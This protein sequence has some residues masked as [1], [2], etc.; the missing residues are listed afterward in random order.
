M[1]QSPVS[2]KPQ[3]IRYIRSKINPDLVILNIPGS[4]E[5]VYI[6]RV[7]WSILN[8]GIMEY[9]NMLFTARYVF[10]YSPI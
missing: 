3:I 7:D 5:C 1:S 10:F 4:K 9:R 8:A 6:P 2:Q